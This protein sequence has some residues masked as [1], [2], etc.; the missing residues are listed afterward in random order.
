MGGLGPTGK[1]LATFFFAP[2]DLTDG[3]FSANFITIDLRPDLLAFFFDVFFLDLTPF[4]IPFLPRD[5]EQ[6][7]R[8]AINVNL[9]VENSYKRL[10]PRH[11]IRSISF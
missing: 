2:F 3:A 4:A 8:N 9:A 1:H 7:N 5:G 10:L 11:S 6:N